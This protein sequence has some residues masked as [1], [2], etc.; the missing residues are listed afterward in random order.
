M[1]LVPSPDYLVFSILPEK[2][3]SILK[4]KVKNP[5]V[6]GFLDVHPSDPLKFKQFIIWM[7]RQ[8]LYRKQSFPQVYPEYHSLFADEWNAVTDLSYNNFIKL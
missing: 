8:D 2:I 6:L 1:N 5:D 3:K 4:Q 7:K